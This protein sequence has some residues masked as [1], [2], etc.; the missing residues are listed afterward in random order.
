MIGFLFFGE[1]KKTVF[2]KPDDFM[3]IGIAS[4]ALGGEYTYSQRAY[5]ASNHVKCTKSAIYSDG[6]L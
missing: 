1:S 4:A 6:N 5:L 2:G 3:G